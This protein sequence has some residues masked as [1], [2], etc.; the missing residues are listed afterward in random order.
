[1]PTARGG[2]RRYF[3]KPEAAVADTS[4][5][6]MGGGHGFDPGRARPGSEISRLRS[7]FMHVAR[8][9]HAAPSRAPAQ[10]VKA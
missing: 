5:S 10:Y 1:M 6:A 3:L 8:A 4:S 2:R 7:I 9:L